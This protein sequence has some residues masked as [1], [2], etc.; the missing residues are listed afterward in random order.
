MEND[1]YKVPSKYTADFL[2]VLYDLGFLLLLLHWRFG[3]EKRNT[4]PYVFLGA[5][6]KVFQVGIF[7][8]VGVLWARGGR[9]WSPKTKVGAC[10]KSTF[11][12]TPR[13]LLIQVP[14]RSTALFRNPC[15]ILWF[16]KGKT[17]QSAMRLCHILL[18]ER[19][20]RNYI[21]SAAH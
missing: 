17:T 3:E 15:H 18:K 9:R 13:V 11:R 2:R 14:G 16:F 21:I 1:G 19:K 10:I 5:K 4:G 8:G 12:L 20:H 6:T 7:K